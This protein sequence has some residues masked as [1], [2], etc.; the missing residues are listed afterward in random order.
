LRY[1]GTI[2]VVV[3]L[4]NLLPA[5]PLDGGRVLRAAI[6]YATKSLRRA[7]QLASTVGQGYIRMRLALEA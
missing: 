5:F 3:A 1:L 6:W 7:T 4:F 2:N